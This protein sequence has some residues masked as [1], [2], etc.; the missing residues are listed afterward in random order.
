[1]NVKPTSG[2]YWKAHG[3]SLLLDYWR[4]GLGLAIGTFNRN[5]VVLD[6]NRTGGT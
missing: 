5:I 6:G 4:Q 3:M 1:M 2:R